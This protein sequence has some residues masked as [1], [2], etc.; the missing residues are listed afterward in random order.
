MSLP[1]SDRAAR[2][3]EIDATPFPLGAGLVRLAA[4]D[5]QDLGFALPGETALVHLA[6]DG[7]PLLISMTATSDPTEADRSELYVPA[8]A[9]AIN[10]PPAVATPSLPR[11]L[12]P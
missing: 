12:L 11:P 8:L 7:G 6:A 10:A 1:G 2:P 9:P 5:R 4:H 3:E